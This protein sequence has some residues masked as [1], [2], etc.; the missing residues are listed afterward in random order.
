[1]DLIISDNIDELCKKHEY[2]VDIWENISIKTNFTNIFK[3]ACTNGQFYVA[4][5]LHKYDKTKYR[6]LSESK[7][8]IHYDKEVIFRETCIKGHLN[9]A[10]W[11]YHLD[12]NTNIYAMGQYH[13][14]FH[15]ACLNGHFNM[16][17]WLWR[18][19]EHYCN[20]TKLST[21]HKFD[22]YT[23]NNLLFHSVCINGHA[24]IARWL[25]SLDRRMESKFNIRTNNDWLYN[26]A[27]KNQLIDMVLFFASLENDYQFTMDNQQITEYYIKNPLI[28]AYHN[29]DIGEMYN[30]LKINKYELTKEIEHDTC[31]ICYEEEIIIDNVSNVVILPCEHNVCINCV[32]QYYYMKKNNKQCALCRQDF[33]YFDCKHN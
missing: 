3:T 2:S 27:C 5:W 16:V 33:K 24:Q 32:I 25:W 31:P 21:R 6:S 30:L 28:D 1:M 29:K 14:V 7:L 15:H 18:I 9:I 20:T 11:L 23:N 12:K 13:N 17:Q 22:I 8:R 10:Q 19:D 26:Q 4:H